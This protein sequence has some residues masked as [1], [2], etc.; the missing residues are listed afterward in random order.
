MA[1][2]KGKEK[3]SKKLP[4]KRAPQRTTTKAHHA[5]KVKPPSKRVKRFIHIDKEEK[6]NPAKDSARFTNRFCELMFPILVERN[7][8]SE[9]LLTP[10]EHLVQF[11]IPRIEGRQ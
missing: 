3:A 11:V 8:H 2:K 9:H 1:I 6:G 5:P 4:T 7:Y 10:L